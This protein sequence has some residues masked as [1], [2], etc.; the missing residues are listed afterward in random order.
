MFKAKKCE[1]TAIQIHRLHV[2]K[3]ATDAQRVRYM[4]SSHFCTRQTPTLYHVI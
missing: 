4:Q 3:K 1:V 2:P